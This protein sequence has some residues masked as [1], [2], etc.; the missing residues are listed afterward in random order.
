MSGGRAR[1]RPMYLANT[2]MNR[3][4]N[5]ITKIIMTLYTP[6]VYQWERFWLK[7]YELEKTTQRVIWRMWVCMGSGFLGII[8][9]DISFDVELDA[10]KSTSSSEIWR[11]IIATVMDTGIYDRSYNGLIEHHNAVI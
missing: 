11:F 3:T 4:R 1:G 8:R 7:S 5:I 6:Y 9:N 10:V 2:S